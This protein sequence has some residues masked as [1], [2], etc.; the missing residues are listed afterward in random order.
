VRRLA[1]DARIQ[2]VLTAGN[3]ILNLGR[4]S[5]FATDAQWRALVLRDG[6]CRMPGC[7]APAA[8]CDVDHLEAW[9]LG[10]LTDLDNLVLWCRHHHTEKH[11]PGVKVLGDAHDLRLQL[12]DGTI[13][14]CPTK[15]RDRAAA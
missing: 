8:W 1:E 12:A 2:R 3:E 10:G 13:I 4:S 11:R 5:R 9:D 15:R 14:H 7:R 6:G